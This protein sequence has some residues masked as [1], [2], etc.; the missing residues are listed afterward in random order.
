LERVR[1]AER[2]PQGSAMRA[3]VFDLDELG[4]LG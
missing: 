4:E 1:D 3:L 2:A